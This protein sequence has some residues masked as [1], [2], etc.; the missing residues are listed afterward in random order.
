MTKWTKILP[1]NQIWGWNDW[2]LMIIVIFIQFEPVQCQEALLSLRDQILIKNLYI[3]INIKNSIY[4]K[5][6]Y[7]VPT[8]NKFLDIK[9]CVCLQSTFLR[10]QQSRW[11]LVH[12]QN[13]NALYT[14]A[15][16]SFGL[17][18]S[19]YIIISSC[20]HDTPSVIKLFVWIKVFTY[21]TQTKQIWNWSTKRS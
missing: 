13:C 2:H 8:N 11:R 12:E 21:K 16:L 1:D 18:Q 19:Y 3:A 6:I 7:S 14:V 10:N 17:L 4:D 15:R 5:G 20:Y 9:L